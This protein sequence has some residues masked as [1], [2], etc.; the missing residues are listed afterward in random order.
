MP[1]YT[2]PDGCK[3][4]YTAY[5]IDTSKQV[6]IFLNGT[7]QT[8]LYW[9]NHVPAFSKRYGLLFYDARGQGQS[10]L[11]TRPIS[12]EQHVSDLKHLLE[13]LAVDKAHLVGISHG[14][15][16][17]LEFTLEIPKVVDQLVLCSVSMQTSQRCRT[18]VRSW[19]EILKLSGL[20][21]MA[22]ATLPT[23]FGSKFL[24]DHQKIL[25]K[26]VNA[27]TIRNSRK[28][29]IAQLDAILSYPAPDIIT[30]DFDKPTLVLS[31]SEDPLVEPQDVRQLAHR[32]RADHHQLAGIGHS[33]P[34][35]APASFQ[36]LVLE[37]LQDRKF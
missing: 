14:A 21:T 32:C 26:I 28:A 29:L 18:V 17:A 3:I 37:F 19:L 35:E 2:T 4:Y 36:Q 23:V 6:V 8:T 22:W 12:L 1:Y 33:I 30:V 25:D 10:N 24:E 31:G 13:H 34:A 5:G 7:T 11:G 27:V 20:K 15:R 9:G 16:L